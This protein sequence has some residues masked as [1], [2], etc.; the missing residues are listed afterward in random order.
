[1]ADANVIE[2][3]V[4]KYGP[5][6]KAFET[7]LIGSLMDR[8]ALS[9]ADAAI[10]VEDLKVRGVIE[11]VGRKFGTPLIRIKTAST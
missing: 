6:P 8:F 3:V 4:S 5:F 11:V 7:H 2:Y 1:M 9:E 10:L